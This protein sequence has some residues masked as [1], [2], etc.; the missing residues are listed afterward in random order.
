MRVFLFFF[1]EYS[2]FLV[3]LFLFWALASGM[4]VTY[5]VFVSSLYLLFFSVWGVFFLGYFYFLL[6]D[7]LAC[8]GSHFAVTGLSLCAGLDNRLGVIYLW[9]FI[10]IYIFITLVTLVYC[11]A[12]NYTE[13]FSFQ[14][15]VIFIFFVGGVLFYVNSLVLFFFAY[16]AFLIPSFLILYNFAKTRKAVEAAFLMFFWTQLGAVFLIFNF[17][18]VFFISGV[19]GFSELSFT[20]FT[21]CELSFL[22]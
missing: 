10:Y 17:Q 22:F 2:L 7:Q 12:Y 6:Y 20:S 11:F 4:C 15:Y 8:C 3:V 14:F 13:L 1:F 5:R 19:A 21:S 18:Y 9:P 16:E